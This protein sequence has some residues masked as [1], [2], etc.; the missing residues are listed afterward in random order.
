ML[1][2]SAQ[3]LLAPLEISLPGEGTERLPLL[4]AVTP[5]GDKEL[6]DLAHLLANN[7]ERSG[8]F[9][10]SVKGYQVPA[11]QADLRKLLD[12][13]YPLEIFLNREDNSHFSWRLYD[14]HDAHLIKGMN[15]AKR[16]TFLHGYADNLADE[17]WPILT[18]QPGSFST[19]IAYVKRKQSASKRQ[20]H[21]VCV[22]NSDGSHEQELIDKIGTYVGLYFDK[23]NKA[24]DNPCLFCSEFTRS[25]VRLISTNFQRRKKIV[26]NVPGTCVGISV[27]QD[28]NKAVYCRS[29]TIWQYSYDPT[30]MRSEHAVLIKNEGNNVSP[31]LLENGDVIFCSDS[32]KVRK[33]H[34]KATGPQICLYRAQ[35]RSISLLTQEGYCV[36]PSYCPRTKKIA[37]SKKVQG[38]MQLYTYDMRTKD[39]KQIT[40]DQGHK[41]DCCWSPCGNYIVYCHQQGKESRIAIIHATMKKRTFLT[42]ANDYCT[43][44]AWSGVFERV[45]MVGAVSLG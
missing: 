7:L 11:T 3:E 45:P 40:H 43:C 21:V 25:N 28:N 23:G 20:R 17:L 16:G 10:V 24:E 2:V 36:G 19:K 42:P 1:L 38:I 32:R 29:G 34:P 33:N 13:S 37:F 8:Q 44:P 39:T 12:P 22:I 4:L 35:D 5:A 18:K 15:Y 14:V 27:A 26:L 31:T 30:A 41:I 9:K 6:A